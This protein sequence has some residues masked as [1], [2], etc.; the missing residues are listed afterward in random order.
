[1]H[2]YSQWNKL[3]WWWW[4]GN[5]SPHN[6]TLP[7]EPLISAG[8]SCRAEC[9]WT[10]QK[11]SN[12][13]YSCR[14]IMSEFTPA[15]KSMALENKLMWCINVTKMHLSHA[16][17]KNKLMGLYC[18]W[19]TSVFFI[20]AKVFALHWAAPPFAPEQTTFQKN[21][22]SFIRFFLTEGIPKILVP[23]Q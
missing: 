18:I 20:K 4:D 14:S 5:I 11:H 21:F 8:C 13:F 9:C 22:T 15:I 12:F 17:V 23:K 10:A 2:R 19:K 1:M 7:V 6:W 3:M 16:V